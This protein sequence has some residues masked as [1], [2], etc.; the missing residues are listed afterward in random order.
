MCYCHML[1]LCFVKMPL[2]IVLVHF[3]ISVLL[4]IILCYSLFWRAQF[5]MDGCFIN[6]FY[7]FWNSFICLLY[8]GEKSQQNNEIP[9]FC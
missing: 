2:F 1:I 7:S 8:K 9:H 6:Q 5:E 3:G 4:K